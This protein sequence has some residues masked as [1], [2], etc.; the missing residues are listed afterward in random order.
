MEMG[1]GLWFFLESFSTGGCSQF[2]EI[3]GN[4]RMV[5]LKGG[6]ISR[7]ICSETLC[8]GFSGSKLFLAELALVCGETS[9][10]S[11][12]LL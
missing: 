10:R 11:S 9:T 3:T 7:K 4:A 2:R 8:H 12:K 1:V 5:P 6:S